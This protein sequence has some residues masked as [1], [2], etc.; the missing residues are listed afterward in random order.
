MTEVDVRIVLL[1]IAVVSPHVA[2]GAEVDAIESP[3]SLSVIGGGA[4]GEVRSPPLHCLYC[5]YRAPFW[6]KRHFFL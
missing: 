2:D 4:A 3:C 6:K 1:T 5:G